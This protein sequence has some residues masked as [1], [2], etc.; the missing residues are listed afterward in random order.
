[1]ENRRRDV[2]DRALRARVQLHA[3]PDRGQ[4]APALLHTSGLRDNERSSPG[5]P[6]LHGGSRLRFEKFVIV[7]ERCQSLIQLER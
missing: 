1:M 6:T 2:E 4:C 3:R 7:T 5:A